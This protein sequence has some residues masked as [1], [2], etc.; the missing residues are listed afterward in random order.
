LDHVARFPVVGGM[1]EAGGNDHA[2]VIFM[3]DE[4]VV[5]ATSKIGVMVRSKMVGTGFPSSQ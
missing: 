1:I 5:H 3:K 2:G 4:A